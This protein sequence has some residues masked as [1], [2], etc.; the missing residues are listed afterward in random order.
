[1]SLLGLKHA[2]CLEIKRA[3]KPI[4]FNLGLGSI[5]DVL[6]FS[7]CHVRQGS[8][9]ILKRLFSDK[10]DTI[11]H[12]TPSRI[13]GAVLSRALP[14][15][16]P[17]YADVANGEHFRIKN[18]SQG[19]VKKAAGLPETWRVDAPVFETRV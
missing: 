14:C 11:P 5:P 6:V 4:Y 17:G 9:Q 19:P 18:F 13:S 7:R 12:L 2:Y 10:A 3:Q 1:M 16:L 15:Q 8:F